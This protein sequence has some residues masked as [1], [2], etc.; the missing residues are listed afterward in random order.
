MDIERQDIATSD[1]SV[2]S[3]EAVA[4]FVK[5]KILAEISRQVASAGNL[6]ETSVYD[7]E[8]GG[9]DRYQSASPT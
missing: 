6:D 7:K 2:G 4:S 1:S 8:G 5:S 3:E 9:H